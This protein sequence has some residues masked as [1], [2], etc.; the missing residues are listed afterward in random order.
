M[1]MERILSHENMLSALK[2]V[3]SNKVSYGFDEMPVQNL[4]QHI[5]N[6]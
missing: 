5:I 2:R 4:R 6:N 3:V 1:L